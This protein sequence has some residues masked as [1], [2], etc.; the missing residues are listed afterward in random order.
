VFSWII[1]DSK[2]SRFTARGADA[3][4]NLAANHAVV[5]PKSHDM[6]LPELRI[7]WKTFPAIKSTP[8]TRRRRLSRG[9]P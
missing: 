6:K 1:H 9:P 8:S 2:A 5:N 3:M 7:I 4:V